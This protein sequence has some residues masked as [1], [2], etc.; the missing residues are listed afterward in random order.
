VVD[1]T[2]QWTSTKR[3][4]ISKLF[5]KNIYAKMAARHLR[6]EKLEVTDS[7]VHDSATVTGQDTKS[8]FLVTNNDTDIHSQSRYRIC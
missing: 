6:D 5:N 7:D 8:I 2:C 1:I 3:S 4:V